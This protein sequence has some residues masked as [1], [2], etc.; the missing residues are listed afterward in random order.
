MLDRR[1]KYRCS[2]GIGPDCRQMQTAGQTTIQIRMPSMCVMRGL[3]YFVFLVSVALLSSF[4]YWDGPVLAASSNPVAANNATAVPAKSPN[5]IL[6][7]L[8]T[9]RADRMGFLRSEEH[10]S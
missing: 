8:D 6:I 1:F 10:T 2:T 7:T 4:C 9:T 3:T 5:I